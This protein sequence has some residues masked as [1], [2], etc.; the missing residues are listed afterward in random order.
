M[1]HDA[2]AAERIAPGG[3]RRRLTQLLGQLIR[4]GLVGG[5][6]TLT[7]LG[8]AWW[9]LFSW[10]DLSPFLVNFFAF[11]VAFQV[12]FWGH[13]R[14]TFRQRGSAA[15]FL[16]VTISGFCIN[17]GLLWLFLMAG[18]QSGFVAICL[19]VVLVPLFVFAGARL[20]V[21]KQ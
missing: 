14:F 11:V 17:N 8:V 2:E 21:F 5:A 9:V 15:K 10:P 13:S 3:G 19:S 7:H 4:F 6:A 20:W 16:A 12:S 1:T 18:V